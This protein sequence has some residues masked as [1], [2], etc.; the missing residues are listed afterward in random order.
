MAKKIK[1]EGPDGTQIYTISSN[2]DDFKAVSELKNLIN[3][4]YDKFKVT[5]NL[6]P[7]VDK[8][9]E[10]VKVKMKDGVRTLSDIK[11]SPEYKEVRDKYID[12]VIETNPDNVMSI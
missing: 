11:E 9:G 3:V 1:S 12:S 10:Y 5:E 8:L 2:P 4:K 7:E 6:K